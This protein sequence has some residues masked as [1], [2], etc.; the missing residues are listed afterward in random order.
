[1]KCTSTTLIPPVK[2]KARLDRGL[3][4]LVIRQFAEFWYYYLG[5]LVAL[6]VTQYIQ[7]SLPFYAKELVDLV[8]S[9][10][11]PIE[12]SKFFWLALGIVFFRT[13]SR[14]LFFYPARV[15]QRELRT[16]MLL[17][18]ESS[19]PRRYLEYPAGQLYQIVYNDFENIR[20][21]V[22]FALLQVGNVIVAL[23][24]LLPRMFSYHAALIL[25]LSP[26][27]IAVTLFTVI[28]SRN[29]YYYRKNQDM[30]G[31]VQNFIMESYAGKSTIKNYHAEIPFISLFRSYSQQELWYTYRA[32]I[33]VSY[34]MPLIPLG[35]GLS[36][37]W[38]AQVIYQHNLGVGALILFSGFIFLFLEP[39]TYLSWIGVV[40]SR[41]LAAWQR[42]QNLVVALNRQHPDEERIMQTNPDLNQEHYQLEFWEDEISLQ[43]PSGEW[44]VLVGK[45]GCGKTH[46]LMQLAE[47]YKLR[48]VPI[49]WVSATPYIYN[50]TLLNNIVLGQKVDQT[51]MEL[52]K[53]LIV[54]F[55][56]SVL[57]PSVDQVLQ[58]MVGGNGKRISGGQ[59]KRVGVIRSLISGA[60]I[61]IWDD[62]FSSIDVVLERRVGDRLR[63]LDLLKGVTV[64][65]SSHR[66]T[67]VRF[68]DHLIYIEKGV[69][70]VDSG[71]AQ[72]LISNQQSKSHEY[73]KH[74]MA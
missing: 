24:V 52:I 49:S 13:F 70:V 71:D 62:P 15:L 40:F 22:G 64:I 42:I 63:K 16:E 8:G 51:K 27:F 17:R 28:V 72:T 25:P 67:T 74:Q 12:L 19:T 9:A 14:L 55:E 33:G 56:L 61:V 2:V 31:E 35:V 11:G 69:G 26:M 5:A 41:S 36:L 66:L 57:A 39:L 43:I 73:F 54:L 48:G 46:L 6:V 53:E 47:L 10:N 68:C 3:L 20:T 38:G 60:K 37:L 18:I 21:L 29:R 45:T 4:Q 1:M 65:V 59:A 58:L 50:D 44:S 30:Q 23:M 7:S 32:G 34:S